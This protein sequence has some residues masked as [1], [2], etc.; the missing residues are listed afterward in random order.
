MLK[1][2]PFISLLFQWILHSWFQQSQLE[3]L[4]P[5]GTDHRDFFFPQPSEPHSV[6]VD[7]SQEKCSV[8]RAVD[9]K[10]DVV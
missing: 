7:L 3:I 6:L 4:F 9:I 2:N 1:I 8:A 5:R 10:P